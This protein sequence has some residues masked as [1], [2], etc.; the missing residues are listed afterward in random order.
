MENTKR[1]AEYENFINGQGQVI[2]ALNRVTQ[3]YADMD[4]EE[5]IEMCNDTKKQLVALKAKPKLSGI[6]KRFQEDALDTMDY[7]VD[8]SDVY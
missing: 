3:K 6:E 5:F 1:V 4:V 8:E 2:Q 7:G